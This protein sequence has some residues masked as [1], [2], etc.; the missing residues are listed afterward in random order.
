MALYVEELDRSRQAQCWLL[1]KVYLVTASTLVPAQCTGNDQ[2]RASRQPGPRSLIGLPDKA[3]GGKARDC[4][5]TAHSAQA[6]LTSNDPNFGQL[7]L[8]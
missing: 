2:C 6:K 8:D 7:L 4:C 1:R 3:P 5:A